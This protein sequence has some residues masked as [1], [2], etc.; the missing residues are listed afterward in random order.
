MREI[1]EEDG[2]VIRGVYERSDAKVR[3]QE[4]ME[5]C[6]GVIGEPFDTDVE[7]EENGVRYLVDVKDGQKT[8]FFLDQKYNRLAIQKLCRGAKVLGLFYPY[9]IL[10]SERGPRRGV[11]CAGS[12]RFGTWGSPGGEKRRSQ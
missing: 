5:L 6:K 7:I 11:Q 4:G 10:R 3:R 1:L 9:G 12:G 2:V 8:G